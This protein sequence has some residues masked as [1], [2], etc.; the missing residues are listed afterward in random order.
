MAPAAGAVSAPSWSPDGA[1]VIY[2][3]IAANRSELSLD[4]R[5][6]TADEDVFPFRAQ[7][8]SPTE[9]IYTADGKIKKRSIARR[10]GDADRVHRGRVVHAHALQARRPRLRFAHARD[11]CAAS[12]R[13]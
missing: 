9:V 6:I 8:T 7:W 5:D 2:N 12:W 4:G 11:R 10:I 3:V 1:T 13:R